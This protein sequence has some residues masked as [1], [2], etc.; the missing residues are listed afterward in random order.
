MVAALT[1]LSTPATAH[2]T[3]Q[4]RLAVLYFDN[5]TANK[6][7]DVLQKG[8]ADMFITD[9]ASV[10]GIVV[11]ERDK[12]QSIVKEL[13]LQRSRFFNKHTAVRIGKQLGA[14]HVVSG[15]FAVVG[16]NIRIG[17]RLIRIRNGQIVVGKKVV[18]AKRAIFELEQKLV[19][20]F[21]NGL[22]QATGA[23]GTARPTRAARIHAYRPRRG[24]TYIP[25]IAMLVD[26]SKGLDLID[27]GKFRAAA[28]RLAAVAAQAPSFS[29]A[30]QRQRELKKRVKQAGLRRILALDAQVKALWKKARAYVERHKRL[31]DEQVA[32]NALGYRFVI[33]RLQLRALRSQLTMK[34][35]NLVLP[36]KRRAVLAGIEGYVKN[37]LALIK[38]IARYAK[39]HTRVLQNGLRLLD[40]RVRLSPEDQ[41]VIRE[42]E[43]GPI[44]LDAASV[45]V[46]LG[47]FLLAGRDFGQ[48]RK[49]GPL[50]LSPPPAILSARYQQLGTRLLRNVIKDLDKQAKGR[51][52]QAEYRAISARVV[53][54][55]ALLLH[56]KRDAAVAKWQ[57]V[58]DLY[59]TSR[60]YKRVERLIKEQLGLKKTYTMRT[61]RRYQ[62]GLKTCKDMDLRVGLGTIFQK[63][64][65]LLGLAGIQ[66]TIKEIE[67]ACRARHNSGQVRLTYFWPYLYQ[68]AALKVGR[69]GIC[70]SF[71]RLIKR[72]VQEG[73]PPRDAG[74]YR[75]NYTS[76]R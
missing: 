7:L 44:R 49:L 43:L 2:A 52:R 11:V 24:R 65:R 74:L 18:G 46:R 48:P 9:L 32:K 37:Q 69:L 60:Q 75:K 10:R 36:T 72:A 15:S 58:L 12:L 55:Q 64:I 47:Q 39:L 5:N 70:K 54:G 73:L 25:S 76:C 31:R 71:E 23:A 59:P 19:A 53:W 62:K 42:A 41:R 14:T 57:E 4:P 30:K 68:N 21:V 63:R 40:R 22:R 17:A 45:S 20:L 16:E 6:Q 34:Q 33:G 29:L 66:T 61:L 56:G 51:A 35:P 1:L 26:Y 50:A 8:L 67:K 28:L 3:K 13:K 27:R 38:G